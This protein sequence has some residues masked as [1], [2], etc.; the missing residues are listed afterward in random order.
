D[1]PAVGGPV[2]HALG[3]RE[4]PRR[5]LELAV[6]RVWHPERRL[7]KVLGRQIGAL[8]HEDTLHS[9]PG[10]GPSSRSAE[11]AAPRSRCYSR[12]RCRAARTPCHSRTSTCL[13]PL[14]SATGAKGA[15]RS[16]TR[17]IRRGTTTAPCIATTT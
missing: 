13:S 16:P 6:R 17:A 1:L 2:V 15:A 5:R 14:A 4:Q 12:A 7:A 10:R 9:F 3:A 8:V 11:C